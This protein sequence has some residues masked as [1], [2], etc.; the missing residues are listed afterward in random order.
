MSSRGLD[1]QSFAQQFLAE[2]T[3]IIAKLDLASI[4]KAAALIASTRAIGGRLFILGVG[5]SAANAS[6]A[7]NDFRKIAALKPTLPPI[8]CRTDRAR[9]RRRL[10]F[11]LRWLAAHQ[12]PAVR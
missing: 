1:K 2:A 4:E 6:H 10:E 3:S 7:V 5:G 11:D 12:P 8:M 9:Q